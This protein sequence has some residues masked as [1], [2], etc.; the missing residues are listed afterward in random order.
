[1]AVFYYFLVS[2]VRVF[3]QPLPAS[4]DDCVTRQQDD[5]VIK[6]ERGHPRGEGE[7]LR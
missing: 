5:S 3:D 4:G 7:S 6:V 1:M 2:P